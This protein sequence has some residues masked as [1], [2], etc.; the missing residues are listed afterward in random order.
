ME[1]AASDVESTQEFD[2]SAIGHADAEGAAAAAVAEISFAHPAAA[3]AHEAPPAEETVAEIQLPPEHDV[4]HEVETPAEEP[5][6]AFEAAVEPEAAA[7]PPPPPPPPAVEEHHWVAEPAE[8]TPEDQAHFAPVAAAAAPE[9]AKTEA[10]P[11]W[12]ELLKSVEEPGAAGASAM[13]AQAKMA[14]A[15]SPAPAAAAAP[16]VDEETVRTAVHLCLENAL[17]T[18]VEEITASILRRFGK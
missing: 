14:S 4:D 2:L 13:S 16:A 3:E 12:N 1:S 9:K 17:P 18:L 5:A 7:P 8:V 10:P 15:P 6:P 11:D